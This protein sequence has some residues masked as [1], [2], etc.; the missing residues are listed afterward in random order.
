MLSIAGTSAYTF[1][2]S[3]SNTSIAFA[4]II[5]F[6]GLVAPHIVR[7]IIGSD[8]RFL[9]PASAAFGATFLLLCDML[10]RILSDV[11]AIPIG[12][13]IS[14]I[15]APIFLYLIIRQRRTIW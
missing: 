1:K 2:R 6:V 11:D 7:M 10:T 15:G 9:I 13:V 12:V 4:G 14:F 8:N 5:G 3:T